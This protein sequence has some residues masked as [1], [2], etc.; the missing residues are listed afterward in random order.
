MTIPDTDGDE[1]A[2]KVRRPGI[3]KAFETDLA[4]MDL[5]ARIAEF[6]ILA[7]YQN[8]SQDRSVKT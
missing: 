1:V 6:H 5:V 4:A 8:L 7:G 2:V 3:R